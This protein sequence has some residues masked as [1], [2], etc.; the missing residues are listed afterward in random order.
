MDLYGL[1]PSIPFTSAMHILP[2]ENLI[3]KFSKEYNL[4]LLKRPEVEYFSIA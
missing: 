2:S 1:F 4:C 3:L